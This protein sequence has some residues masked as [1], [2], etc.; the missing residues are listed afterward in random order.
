MYVR[1]WPTGKGSNSTDI[2]FSTLITD[3]TPVSKFRDMGPH[4]FTHN[5]QCVNKISLVEFKSNAQP[6]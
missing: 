3:H 5:T 1:N 4:T 2:I 6:T